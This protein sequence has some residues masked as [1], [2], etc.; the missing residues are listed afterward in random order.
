M[1]TQTI[2]KAT[3]QQGLEK[4]RSTVKASKNK[5]ILDAAQTLFAQHGYHN[6]GM[7][8]ISALA[9]VSSATLYKHFDSKEELAQMVI[10]RVEK[11]SPAKANQLMAD[12][13]TNNQSF[14]PQRLGAMTTAEGI[15]SV[16]F[17]RV[18]I[19]LGKAL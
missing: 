10:Q 8:E 17:N 13:L 15:T 4:Y 12:M 1:Q 5:A 19:A 16:V 7:K 11:E 18:K 14:V 2:E 3:P 6:T 9:D